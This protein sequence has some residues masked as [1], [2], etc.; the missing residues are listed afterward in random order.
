M[1]R[2]QNLN[3]NLNASGEERKG[4][5]A[6]CECELVYRKIMYVLAAGAWSFNKGASLA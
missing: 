3:A 4:K 1:T 5:E 6:A 2:H